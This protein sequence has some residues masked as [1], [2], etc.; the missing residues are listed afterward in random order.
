MEFLQNNIVGKRI[1]D[2]DIEE[3]PKMKADAKVEQ[4]FNLSPKE[5]K[6]LVQEALDIYPN[7]ANAYIY[8]GYVDDDLDQAVKYSQ[9]AI[10][11][12]KEELAYK[13]H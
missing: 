1:D 11:V 9:K 6:K 3:T 8:L 4:A 7:F 5:G 13:I 10:K 12:A 2:L